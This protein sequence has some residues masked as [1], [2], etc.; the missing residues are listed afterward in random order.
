[1]KGSSI[2][3]ARKPIT[4]IP[5]FLEILLLRVSFGLLRT[6]STPEKSSANDNTSHPVV[7]SQGNNVG[8]GVPGTLRFGSPIVK[9]P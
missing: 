8:P 3:Y 1:M 5:D 6:P 2:R 4:A 7:I 9:M